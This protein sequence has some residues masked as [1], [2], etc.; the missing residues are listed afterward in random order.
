MGKVIKPRAGSLAFK[1]RKRSKDITPRMRTWRI[2]DKV[3]LLG[4][5][6]Y[7]VGM[8]QAGMIDDSRSATKGM[9]LTVPVTVLEAPKITIYGARLYQKTLTGTKC[10]GDALSINAKVASMLGVSK[11]DKKRNDIKWLEEKISSFKDED[12]KDLYISVLAITNPQEAGIPKK[13]GD[14]VEIAIGGNDVNSQLEYVKSI[15]GKDITPNQVFEEGEY[16]DAVAVTRGHGWQGVIRRFGVHKQRPKNTGRVR[17]R[18]TLGPWHPAYVMYTT[19]QAGQ[20]G[21][22]RRTQYNNR[23]LLIGDDP[24]KVNIP[25]G[26]PHYGDVKSSFICVKGSV[27]G[28]QKRFVFLRKSIRNNSVQK[29]QILWF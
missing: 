12:K 8:K 13:T 14:T 22:H 24:S 11:K 7:K 19:P 9:E 26:Y 16:V 15:I 28:T 23:I 10:L 20:H 25:G 18:G 5:P 29:P 27:P 4:Y 21:F 17:H 1:P 3:Q 2:T 6:V